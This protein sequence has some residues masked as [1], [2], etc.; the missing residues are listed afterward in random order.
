M[1]L[2]NFSFDPLLDL[3]PW[4]GQRQCTFRFDRINAVTGEHLGELHPVRTNPRLSHDTT[5][6]IKR[7]LNLSLAA[8]DAAQINALQDRVLPFMVF[9]DGTEYPLGKYVFSHQSDQLF[10]SGKI[11]SVVLNDEMYIVDRQITTGFDAASLSLASTPGAAPVGTSF[12]NGQVNRGS[13]ISSVLAILLAELGIQAEVEASPFV[14]NQ[15][16]AAGVTRGTII[17]AM[18]V[19]G[20]YFSPW[21]DNNGVMQFI[22]SFNPATRIPDFDWDAGNQVMRGN[23]LRQSDILDAPNRFVVISNSSANPTQAVFGQA[24]VPINAPNSFENRGFYIPIVVDMQ[25]LTTEQCQA[26]A[27]NLMQRQTVFETTTLTTA[28]D[29]RHDSYNVIKW[30]DELWLELNWT[31]V[32]AEGQAMTHTLRRSYR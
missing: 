11:S 7:Q 3:A 18:A 9:P 25:L 6:I 24:D 2:T 16:W 15:A 30:Q 4:V 23:I 12:A 27:V 8:E 17:E 10:T 22:R 13:I 1:T 31:M 5:R 14:I 20:D 19:A 29:P 21:F 32:L 28:P 26:V